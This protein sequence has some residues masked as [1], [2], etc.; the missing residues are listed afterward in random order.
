ML[1]RILSQGVPHID[2][3]TQASVD[4]I[5]RAPTPGR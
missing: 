3:Y 2:N 1:D 5:E 4:A